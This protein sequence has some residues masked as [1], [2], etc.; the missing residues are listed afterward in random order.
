MSVFIRGLS[1]DIGKKRIVSD[2]DIAGP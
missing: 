2:V 1:V